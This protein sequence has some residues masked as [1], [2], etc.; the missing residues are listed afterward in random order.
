MIHRFQIEDMIAQDTSGVVFRALDTETGNTVAVRRFFPFGAEGGGLQSGE[1]TA[2]QIA[3]SRLADLRHPAL[4]SIICGGC[5]PVDGIPFIATEWI[6]GT[7]LQSQVEHGPLDPKVASTLLTQALEVCELLSHVL[8]EEAVWVET[9]PNSII[10]GDQ[11]SGRPFTF[12]ISPFRWLGGAHENRGFESIASLTKSVMGWNG[13]I[14]G[15]QAGRGL[16]GWHN[17]LNTTAATT[18]LK[19]ARESL[20]ASVGAGPPRPAKRM[21]TRALKTGPRRAPSKKPLWISIVLG[22]MVISVAGGWYLAHQASPHFPAAAHTRNYPPASARVSERPAEPSAQTDREKASVLT[23]Q[24]TA[25]S[26]RD[27]AIT[28]N[29][30]ELLV[31]RNHSPVTVEGLVHDIEKSSSG[32]TIYLLFSGNGDRNAARVGLKIGDSP[33]QPV[34]EKLTPFLGKTV[35]VAGSVIVRRVAGLNRPDIMID[36]VSAVRLAN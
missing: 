18:T 23:A 33:P 17:W 21:A 14:V 30:H 19:E 32:K 12:W 6:E 11:A 4:R 13:Q 27:G 31:D 15:D 7:S 22:L 34:I 29:D 25:A 3:V 16:G 36:D 1:Q 2:Y 9:D 20:A 35:R 28:W 26:Q 8:A 24:K 5:D 10:T